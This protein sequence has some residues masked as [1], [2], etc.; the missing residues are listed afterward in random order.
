[1][2]EKVERERGST[3]EKPRRGGF[4]NRLDQIS[5]SF[6]FTNFP[7]ELGWGDLWK[8]FAKFG[9]VCDVFIPKKMDKWGRKFGFVKFLG[10]R[11]VETLCEKLQEVWWENYKLKV[12][13][14]RFRKGDKKEKAS[15]DDNQSPRLLLGNDFKVSEEVSFKSRLLGE[16]GSKG[17][18]VSF[19]V[20]KRR[21][22]GGGSGIGRK[23]WETLSLLNSLF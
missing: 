14:A 18:Q 9:S 22:E 3:G 11:E 20:A 16:E 4:A 19:G 1:M 12:N 15:S 7:E 2:S 23:P 10:V 8:L 6:F 5:T 13:K 17:D 21:D